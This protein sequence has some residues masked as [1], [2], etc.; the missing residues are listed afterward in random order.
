MTSIRRRLLV[1]LLPPLILAALAADAITFFKAREEMLELLDEMLEASASAAAVALAGAGPT[2]VSPGAV[3]A[4]RIWSA[5][6][7]L[8]LHAGAPSPPAASAPGAATIRWEGREWRV[9]VLE[10]D[11]RTIQAAEP[12][13]PWERR[14][15]AA[16]IEVIT[17]FSV[18]AVPLF[19]VLIWFGV[20]RGLQPLTAITAALGTREAGSLQ[21][22]PETG[23]PAEVQPLVRALNDL[24]RRLA[25][26]LESQRRFVADAAHGLRTPL[27]AVQLQLENLDRARTPEDRAAAI[28]QLKAGVPRAAALV[29]Q[30]LV[31]A[32]LAPDEAAKRP[33]APVALEPLVKGVLVDLHALAERRSIDLGLAHVEPLA[34]AGDGESLRIM[35]ANLV[36]NALRYT[37]PGGVVD[38]RLFRTGGEAVIEVVDTGPGIPAAE[39]ER[40]FGRFQRGAGVTVPGSGLGLAIVAEVVRQHRGT[41]ALGDGEGGRGLRVR[42]RLP[43]EGGAG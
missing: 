32:R 5:D 1:W 4:I 11:G 27:T 37:P 7:R 21:P 15:T 10:R 36:D 12:L 42:V 24:L 31:M 35:L 43:L 41:V 2:A 39:R 14:S 18:A 26:A 13:E 16:A 40:V 9:L 23:L 38:V 28:E 33:A 29:Q 8:L 19:A 34:V 17:P 6:G 20:G 25:A 30:L 3:R 22:M